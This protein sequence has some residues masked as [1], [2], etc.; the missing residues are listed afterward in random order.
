MRSRSLSLA[1]IAHSR[2]IFLVNIEFLEL[3]KTLER[4]VGCWS[5]FEIFSTFFPDCSYPS[6]HIA[7]I[8]VMHHIEGQQIKDVMG[9]ERDLKAGRDWQ[10]DST[11]GKMLTSRICESG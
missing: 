1:L 10:E 3:P 8:S 7:G 4:Y 11:R 6:I 5:H 9:T 2:F